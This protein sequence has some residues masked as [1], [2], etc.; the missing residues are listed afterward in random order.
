MSNPKPATKGADWTRLLAD[1]DLLA[2]LGELLQTYRDA[3]PETRE[4]ALLEVMRRIKSSA[5]STAA[6]AA[7][8]GSETSWAE[9]LAEPPAL[10]PPPQP[11]ASTASPAPPFEPDM[12]TPSF[13]QDRRRY[14]RFK[15]FV[16]VE[17]RVDGSATPVWGNLSNTSLGGCLVETPATVDAGSRIEIG[18]WVTSGQVWVKG[19]VLNG[20]VTRANPSFGVRVKFADM[21]PAERE[22]L[23]QF[24]KFVETTTKG[25]AVDHGYLAQLKR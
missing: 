6:K 7:A 24:L 21:E 18:L 4:E 10:A 9:T 3:P 16:V 25:Y 1:P 20:I 12:F 8:A 2:H 14:P 17:L 15:C 19:L 23:K 22:T 13:G 11:A 5:P